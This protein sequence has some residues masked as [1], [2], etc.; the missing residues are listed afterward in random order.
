MTLWFFILAKTEALCGRTH[1]ILL[2]KGSKHQLSVYDTKPS[3]EVLSC[4][5]YIAVQT[6]HCYSRLA[7]KTI[8]R[9]H[10]IATQIGIGNYR[11]QCDVT[12]FPTRILI[13]RCLVGEL[14]TGV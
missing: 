11:P 4:L 3:T 2:P 5:S 1:D 8:N 7:N 12:L 10:T 6:A 13:L 14:R 9:P